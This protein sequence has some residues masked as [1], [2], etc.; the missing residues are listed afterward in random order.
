MCPLKFLTALKIP[1]WGRPLR[2]ESMDFKDSGDVPAARSLARC[3]SENPV[4]IWG[5]A[6]RVLADTLRLWASAESMRLQLFDH[7]QPQRATSAVSRVGPTNL[8]LQ[9]WRTISVVD[10]I[11]WHGNGTA[12][13]FHHFGDE[14][15]G[16]GADQ[17]AVVELERHFGADRENM[18][19]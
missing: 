12:L 8:Q 14:G 17:R 5:P 9:T 6:G 2:L 10:V 7:R 11:G 16:H 13:R 4:G 19:A 15:R 1:R 3:R 18:A